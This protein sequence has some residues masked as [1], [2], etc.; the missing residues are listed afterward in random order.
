[1]WMAWSTLPGL[2]DG[3]F[4][5][6]NPPAL[7]GHHDWERIIV[8]TT[9]RLIYRGAT[10]GVHYPHAVILHNA[11]QAAKWQGTSRCT[12]RFKPQTT[13]SSPVL[14]TPTIKSVVNVPLRATSSLSTEEVLSIS[15]D[16]CEED[17]RE[18]EAFHQFYQW[19]VQQ[20]GMWKEATPPH[21]K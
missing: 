16:D 11:E 19:R 14:R 6:G 20:S 18:E 3:V 10:V 4:L 7:T 12:R 21:A 9:L 17:N 15:L 13:Q 2:S 5:P 8:G 1:M